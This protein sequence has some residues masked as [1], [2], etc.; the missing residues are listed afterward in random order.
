[1]DSYFNLHGLILLSFISICQMTIQAQDKTIEAK[2][3]LFASKV[4]TTHTI[5]H[6]VE[7]KTK[8]KDAQNLYLT[9]SDA[10]DSYACDWANWAY[11]RLIGANGKETKLTDL[12]W[13]SAKTSWGK[14]NLNK[15]CGGGSLKI[16]DKAIK[17]GI[18]THANSVIHYE[19]P[20]NHKFIEFMVQ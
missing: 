10:G 4:I 19:L 8:I 7:I 20:K 11:P 2:D 3:A 9:V 14:V 15:N 1:M 12:N 16:N 6:A 13:K 17:Y 5:G 18:G